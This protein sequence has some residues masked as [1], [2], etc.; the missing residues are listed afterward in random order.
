M[1][2]S[3]AGSEELVEAL[4]LRSGVLAQEKNWTEAIADLKT[5]LGESKENDHEARL[6]NISTH[7]LWFHVNYD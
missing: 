3:E 5:A 6:D 4:T 1:R 2:Y 7:I